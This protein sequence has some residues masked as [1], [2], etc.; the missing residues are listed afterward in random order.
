MKRT[1][2]NVRRL[3]GPAHYRKVPGSF[4]TFASSRRD[5]PASKLAGNTAKQRRQ[6]N[7]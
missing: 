3:G 7:A 6:D 4:G 2:L 5:T 1:A